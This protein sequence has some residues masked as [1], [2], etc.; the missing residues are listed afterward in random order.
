[1]SATRR[2]G[3]ISWVW[4]Q[5]HSSLRTSRSERTPL[6]RRRSAAPR[7]ASGFMTVA[8]N[9]FR[10]AWVLPMVTLASIAL[11]AFTILYTIDYLVTGGS[12]SA[13]PPASQL[14]Y[15]FFDQDHIT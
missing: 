9:N 14:R 3:R 13:A 2:I 8:T 10:R 1:M 6:W 4:R 5:R 15:F 11:V 12:A 7:V